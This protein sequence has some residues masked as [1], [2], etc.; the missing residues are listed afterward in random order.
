[1]TE[2]VHK[3]VNIERRETIVTNHKYIEVQF[4]ELNIII[5]ALKTEPIVVGLCDDQSGK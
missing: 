2:Y 1:V 4:Y 3:L 5:I